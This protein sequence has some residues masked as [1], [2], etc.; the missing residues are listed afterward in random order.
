MIS[1]KH[2]EYCKAATLVGLHYVAD[3]LAGISRQRSGKGWSY[4]DAGGSRIG[5]PVIRKR[6]NALAIPPAWANVW[7]CPDP[8]G[9]IQVTARDA[10]GRK[11]Y[12]YH[13]LFREA[14]D[15]TKFRYMFEFSEILPVLR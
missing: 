13:L 5:D 12:L 6:L 2:I 3:I 14:R 9:H 11:Q 7:I 4:A 8:D 15:R 10:R 1:S